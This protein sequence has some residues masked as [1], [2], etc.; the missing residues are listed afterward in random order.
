MWTW[1]LRSF[2]SVHSLPCWNLQSDRSGASECSNCAA[3]TYQP[4]IG[5]TACVKCP[6]GKYQNLESQIVCIDCEIGTYATNTGSIF[7][8]RV[9]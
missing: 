1:I 4:A 8:Y 9:P 3:G 6:A 2:F 5:Q 7:V